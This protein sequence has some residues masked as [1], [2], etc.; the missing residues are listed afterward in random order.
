MTAPAAA[1]VLL[2]YAPVLP[3][4]VRVRFRHEIEP[5]KSAPRLA[6]VLLDV[7]VV[8]PLVWLDLRTAPFN[9]LA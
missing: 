8:R 7:A 9:H 4:K 1:A 2:V 3:K 6:A 5:S